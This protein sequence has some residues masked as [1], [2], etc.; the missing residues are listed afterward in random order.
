L[1]T[2][3]IRSGRVLDIAGHVAPFRDLLIRNGLIAEIGAP[4]MDVPEGTVVVSAADRMLIPGLINA[5]SH[6]HGA[7]GK[8]L[9]DAW[10][11]ELLL[12]AGPWINGDRSLEDKYL[13]AQLNAAEMIRKG[14]TAVYDLYAEFPVPTVEGMEAIARAYDDVGMRAVIAPMVADIS[15]F[16]AIPGLIEALPAEARRS[17]EAIRLAPAKA[18][19]DGCRAVFANWSH[20]RSRVTPAIAP[21]IP[22]HCSP[23]FLESCMEL[24]KTF[25]I[26]MH[27]HLGESRIQAVAGIDAYGK[28]LTAY[29]EEIGML[30]PRLTAAHC[31]WLDDDD[32][33]RL[34]DNGCSVAHNPGSNLRL[35]SGIAPVRKMLARGVNVGIGTDGSHCSDNQN[36]FEA[37]RIASFASRTVSVDPTQWLSTGEAATMA[38]AGSARSLGFEGAIGTLAEGTLADIVFLDLGHINYVPFNNP[39]NQLVHTEDAGAV[40]SVMVA[41]QWL[42]KDGK[43]VTIDY[44]R[45]RLQVA[46]AVGRLAAGATELKATVDGLAKYVAGFCLGSHQRPYHINRLCRC[47]DDGPFVAEG[48]EPAP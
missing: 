45:L 21:T 22:L 41:G 20:D 13:S 24:A 11:L 9:G 48:V 6:G 3:V 14:C 33:G 26:G 29:L 46:A 7:L 43:F 31:V 32:I 15:L 40:A 38:T 23:G 16:E 25:D 37:M 17:V 39:V 4:G 8:G 47:A 28:T 35:G 42:L 19:I 44:Q 1:S 34:A 2:V 27:T 18:I 5:H 36:M 12:N 30:S 10:T